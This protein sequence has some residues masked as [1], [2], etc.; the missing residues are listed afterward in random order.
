[1]KRILFTLV[2]SLVILSLTSCSISLLNNPAPLPTLIS[3]P[4]SVSISVTP[5][6]STS[7]LFIPSTT[8]GLLG[9]TPGVPTPTLTSEVNTGSP[10]GPYAVILLDPGEILNIRSAP[11]ADSPVIGSF[12]ANAINV[13]R[14]GPSASVEGD[15]WVE[16]ANPNGGTAWVNSNFLTEYVN[17]AT[18]CDDMRVN[19]LITSLGIA[20]YTHDGGMLSSLVSPVHGMTLYLYRSGNPVTFKSSD[21]QW[22]FDST[23]AHD[24]GAAPGS[25]L[26]TNGDFRDMVLPKLLSVFNASY[27]LNCNTPGVAAS[28]STEPWPNLYAHINYYNVFRSPSSSG[29]L[30]W[31]VWLV[32]VEFV[33]GKPTIFSLINFEW[34]P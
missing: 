23:Y 20:F 19:S 27:T 13:L 2:A 21:A 18:F 30:D 1:M 25:G 28:F 26:E 31:E 4:S 16:V 6:I 17:Q 24:W 11:G 34:E 7:T 33:Q 5:A 9:V 22:V 3:I 10:S 14:T 15:L 12:T 8:F 29:G 32:G